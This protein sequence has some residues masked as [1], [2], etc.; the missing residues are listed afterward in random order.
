MKTKFN[1]LEKTTGLGGG[2]DMVWKT[3]SDAGP[4]LPVHSTKQRMQLRTKYAL[5]KMKS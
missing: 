2:P 1:M 3:F 4:C 5:R